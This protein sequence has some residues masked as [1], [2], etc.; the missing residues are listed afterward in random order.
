MEAAW[1]LSPHGRKTVRVQVSPRIPN[2]TENI[3]E[4]EGGYVS[5]I[6]C[7]FVKE[8]VFMRKPSGYTDE[9]FSKA[10]SCSPSLRQALSRLGLRPAGGNYRIAKERILSLRLDISHFTGQGHLKGKTHTWAKK[11]PLKDLLVECSTYSSYKLKNRLIES[12]VFEHKCYECGLT[13][14]RGVPTPLE[15]EHKNGNN[16]D[17]RIENLTLLCPNC[18][19]LTDTYRGKNKKRKT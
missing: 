10:I 5:H 15:L 12:G 18:H 7:I 3:F 14:W 2:R 6:E 19:A 8:C 17:S 11:I 4:K 1:G 16:K 9:E 13:S